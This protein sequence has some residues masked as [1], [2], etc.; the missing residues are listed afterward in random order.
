MH[1]V[2]VTV[3][4]PE[5]I[6]NDEAPINL[7]SPRHEEEKTRL[8]SSLSR[9]NGKWDAHHPRH[10]LLDALY[11]Y[12]RYEERQT[13]ELDKWRRFYKSASATQRKLLEREV[14]YTAKLDAVAA[15]IAH[16]Q[17]LCN[18]IVENGLRFYEI[19]RPELDDHIRLRESDG[20]VA[21]RVS[22]SQALKHYVR[23]W[24]AGGRGERDA[25]FP[26]ILQALQSLFPDRRLSG[27][28]QPRPAVKVLLPG[29]G[30]GR[31]S[32]EISALGGFE[33]TSNEWSVYMN[34][35]YRY[36]EANPGVASSNVHP[37]IDN[38]SHHAT[39]ADM[40]RGVTFPDSTIDPS[41]VLLVEGDFTKVFASTKHRRQQFDAIVTHFFID[42]ARNLMAYFDTIHA[43]LPVDGYWINFGPLLYGTG[44][45]VQLSLEEIV[46]VVTAMG[47]E[48][49]DAPEVCG[50]LTFEGQ[51]IRGREASY[52]F[53]EKALVKNAYQAQAWVV[54]KI[55]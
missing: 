40:F 3:Q 49:V 41:T 6:V 11:A 37:F 44:P 38:W 4:Q 50:H 55:K 5:D 47:F 43:L 26:C 1:Q 53:N 29:S 16:N 54:R 27:G 17:R 25:A 18:A 2:V 28:E 52:G 20:K 34:L 23:D 22:V 39:T 14:G 9:S 12:V 35:A 10:R 15:L 51:K 30:V 24:A 45:Y 13:A 42:T 32:H 19:D 36:L 33:V 46:S 8:L 7:A 31:L 21:D 48:F